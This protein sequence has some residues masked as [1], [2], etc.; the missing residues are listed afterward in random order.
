[1]EPRQ[2]LDT[3]EMPHETFR[4]LLNM[5]LATRELLTNIIIEYEQLS[6][7]HPNALTLTVNA[8]IAEFHRMKRDAEIVLDWLTGF[9]ELSETYFDLPPEP[10]R[11]EMEKKQNGTAS[12]FP[13]ELPA[14]PADSAPEEYLICHD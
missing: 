14:P 7:S 12:G 10:T 1:M 11:P 6:P 4:A 3:P 2:M 13:R 5:T 8:P 9:G